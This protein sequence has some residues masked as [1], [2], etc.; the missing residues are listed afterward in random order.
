MNPEYLQFG[1]YDRKDKFV[2]NTVD[3]FW[4]LFRKGHGQ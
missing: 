2:K 1:K 3:L 4:K